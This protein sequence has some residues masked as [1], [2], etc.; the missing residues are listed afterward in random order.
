MTYHYLKKRE[1]KKE[2]KKEKK[3]RKKERKRER[4][5][6]FNVHQTWLL[7]HQTSDQK[8][9][10]KNKFSLPVVIGLPYRKYYCNTNISYNENAKVKT[11]LNLKK[12]KKKKKK[13]NAL[14]IFFI[15]N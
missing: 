8:F 5:R 4:E 1:R 3:E 7:I 15:Q 12:K 2:R 13:K 11:P 10:S 6:E 14:H 9:Y